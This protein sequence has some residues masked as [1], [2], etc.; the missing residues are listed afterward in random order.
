MKTFLKTIAILTVVICFAACSDNGEGYS[1]DTLE[2]TPNNISG[3]WMLTKFN[4]M[5]L[6]EGTYCYIRYIRK[7]KKFEMYEN[8]NSMYPRFITGNYSIETDRKKGSILS[9]VYDYGNGEWNNKYIV[10]EL[11][12]NFMVL[13]AD[14]EEGEVCCYERCG[15]IPADIL[16]QIPE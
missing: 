5:E 1:T 13:E 14:S 12:E 9:G 7:D 16:E 8:M 2:V 10:V 3:Y 11:L 4:G 15:G 6:P